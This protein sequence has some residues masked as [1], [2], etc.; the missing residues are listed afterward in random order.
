MTPMETIMLLVTLNG[1]LVIGF[2]AGKF[3]NHPT[4]RGEK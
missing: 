3:S 4:F 2:V 1:M